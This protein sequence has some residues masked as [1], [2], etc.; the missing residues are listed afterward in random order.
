MFVEV[1]RV[2]EYRVLQRQYRHSCIAILI[3]F[4]NV[5]LIVRYAAKLR[6]MSYIKTQ[7]LLEINPYLVVGRHIIRRVYKNHNHFSLQLY[8]A[9]DEIPPVSLTLLI[10]IQN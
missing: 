7:K 9:E 4:Y 8:I 10:Y 5:F 1:S 2:Q 3:L 6:H